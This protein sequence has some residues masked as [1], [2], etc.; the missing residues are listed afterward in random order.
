MRQIVYLILFFLAFRTGFWPT[1]TNL[2]KCYS[3]LGTGLGIPQIL[4]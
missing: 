2:A 4:P 3:H 1:N